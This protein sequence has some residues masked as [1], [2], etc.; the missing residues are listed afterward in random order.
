MYLISDVRLRVR[1]VVVSQARVG[2]VQRKEGALK[3]A[4]HFT[5]H[6]NN[7]RSRL[8][9]TRDIFLPETLHP[10]PIIPSTDTAPTFPLS[11]TRLRWLTAYGG[12]PASMPPSL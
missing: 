5:R 6:N 9:L 10:P 4:F 12:I 3:R 8:F 7:F 2:D 11:S 1:S